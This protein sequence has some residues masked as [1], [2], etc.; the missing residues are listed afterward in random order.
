MLYGHTLLVNISDVA[1]K[2]AA[3]YPQLIKLLNG[4]GVPPDE[5]AQV[6]AY[7]LQVIDADAVQEPS[8]LN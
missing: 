5:R 6:L 1:A 2:A 8:L 3:I 7:V 4:A